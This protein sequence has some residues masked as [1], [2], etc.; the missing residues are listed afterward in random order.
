M[1][2]K[3]NY[4]IY[5]RQIWGILY[6]VSGNMKKLNMKKPPPVRNLTKKMLTLQIKVAQSEIDQSIME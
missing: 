2:K 3:G 5:N 6:R 4:K 1:K